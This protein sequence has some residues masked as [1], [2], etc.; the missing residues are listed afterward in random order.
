[1]EDREKQIAAEE[2]FVRAFVCKRLRARMLYEF[3]R[4]RDKAFSRLAHQAWQI[5]VPE[6]VWQK[7]E[8]ITPEEVRTAL[9][10]DAYSTHV[11][12]KP[13]VQAF[14]LR[15]RAAGEPMVLATACVP[16]LCR[17]ALERHGL[18]EW[19]SAVFSAQELGLEKRDP[20]YFQTVLERLDVSA[21]ACTLF[22]DSPGACRTARAAGIRVVGM[23]DP[24]YAEFEGELRQ[25]CHRY[26]HSFEE[27]L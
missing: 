20:R 6:T 25:I 14:L 21:G 15:C 27:L 4:E 7:S 5:L 18:T 19:F 11:P 26:I 1:M 24:F 10:G 9:A 22:E 13:G 8:K 23:Y 12:L 17:A 2:A 3:S 16:Q